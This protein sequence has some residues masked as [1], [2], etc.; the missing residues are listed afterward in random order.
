MLDPGGCA[1]KSEDEGAAKIESDQQRIHNDLF[2]D[3]QFVYDESQAW[4]ATT[5]ASTPVSK[6]G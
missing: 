3:D 5:N 1:T 4:E 6:V 2:V